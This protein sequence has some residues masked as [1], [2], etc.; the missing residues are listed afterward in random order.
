MSQR[1]R[2]VDEWPTKCTE[3]S[4]NS[5]TLE[6][7][8]RIRHLRRSAGLRL[9]DVAQ[10]AGCSES[11]LSKVENGQVSPSINMLHRITRAMGVNIPSLFVAPV[12]STLFVHRQGNRPVL[13]K[14]ALRSAHG[15]A[16]ESL[17]PN[18][19]HGHLQGALHVIAPGG[20]SDG[21]ISHDG[22]EVGYVVEGTLEL[23]V[24]DKVVT[25]LAGDSFFF[26]SACPHSY[27]NPGK[28]TT[29]VVWI[30]SPPTY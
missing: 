29:R 13:G 4:S 1:P 12:E 23:T 2:S 11:M 7:G 3:P 27:R 6:I 10:N 30:N 19:I 26:D 5:E 9:I 15:L 21:A 17:T 22:E 20:S 16:L 8:P 25:L 24:D 14:N 28:S 18:E